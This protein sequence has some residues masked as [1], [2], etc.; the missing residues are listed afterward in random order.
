LDR[1]AFH[2]VLHL[3][4]KPMD[5]LAN[6]QK[7]YEETMKNLIWPLNLEDHWQLNDRRKAIL[8]EAQELVEALNLPGPH[9]FNP[10]E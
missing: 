2:P 8:I 10:A 5:R 3:P 4:N 6:L 1:Q 7:E 9:W